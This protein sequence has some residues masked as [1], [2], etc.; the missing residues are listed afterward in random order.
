M[1]LGHAWELA[2]KGKILT[3]DLPHELCAKFNCLFE[4]QFG[5]ALWNCSG[6]PQTSDAR[7]AAIN[8]GEQP[9]KLCALCHERVTRCTL[10]WRFVYESSR[11]SC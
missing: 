5:L 6:F 11:G 1:R 2:V 10:A 9:V 3:I 8:L 7:D 4:L